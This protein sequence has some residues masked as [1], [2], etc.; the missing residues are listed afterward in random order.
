MK[1]KIL[2]LANVLALGGLEKVVVTVSNSLSKFEDVTLYSLKGDTFGYEYSRG[3]T[4]I[5]GQS[6]IGNSLSHPILFVKAAL[7]KK[8]FQKKTLNFQR[9]KN[10]I[11]FS[12]FSTVVLSEADILYAR[13][14]REE[15][16]EIKIIG[17]MH[18]T[19]ESYRNTYMKDSYGAF[20]DC[21]KELNS[22][23]VLTQ[24]D[25]KAYSS[26]HPDVIRI[27]NPL[28]ISSEKISLGTHPDKKTI[29]FVGRLAYNSKGLDYLIELAA[30]LPREWK[31]SVA[32]DGPDRVKFETEIKQKNLEN[33]FILKGALKGPQLADH[34]LSS[35]IFVLTSRWEGFGLVITEAMSKGLPVVAFDSQG[36][37]EI[38]GEN[39]EYGLLIENGNIDRFVTA[40]NSLILDEE[41]RKHYVKQSLNRVSDYKIENIIPQWLSIID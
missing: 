5:V 6:L 36:P 11:D 19:Y 17:W 14:I 35:N 26:I 29:S 22:I 20:L 34:Y 13:Y 31:I 9:V 27:N 4:T 7:G 15:N 28:T 38:I 23:V 32:G 16:P 12:K 30:Q 40:V 21:L 41:L 10:D 8:L 24:A 1:T 33:R 2:F 3:L 25:K 39:N 37:R 18:S